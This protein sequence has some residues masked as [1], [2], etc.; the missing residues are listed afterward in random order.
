MMCES[1]HEDTRAM[2][3][4]IGILVMIAVGFAGFVALVMGV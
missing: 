2:W 4:G 1:K 3:H